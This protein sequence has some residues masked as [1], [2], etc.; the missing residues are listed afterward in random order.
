MS[1]KQIMAQAQQIYF[2]N[3]WR[4]K[5]PQY[6]TNDGSFVFDEDNNKAKYNPR[7]NKLPDL[8]TMWSSYKNGAESRGVRADY[9]TFKNYYDRIKGKQNR[10]FLMDLQ[11]AE[12]TGMSL[13][14]IHDALR[15]DPTLKQTLINATAD[16]S[17]ESN[18]FKSHYF[19]PKESTFSEMISDNLGVLSAAGV[20]TAAGV[21]YARTIPGGED[22]VKN[23][24]K[25]LKESSKKLKEAK[26]KFSKTRA[27]KDGPKYNELKTDVDDAK[28]SHSKLKKTKPVE[29][30][31][32]LTK[33]I[34]MGKGRV[35]TSG[36]AAA[37]LGPMVLES[38]LKKAGIADE[39]A[40]TAGSSASLMAGLGMLGMGILRKNPMAALQGVAQTYSGGT[41]LYNQMMSN[42]EEPSQ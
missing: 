4:E 10:D 3:Y 38:G 30:Y 12:I 5:I 15:D 26:E 22:A 17:D 29:R 27:K 36:Y 2:N 20:A 25:E 23:Y 33:N 39:S 28:S 19:P 41:N 37:A 32:S 9:L 6:D 8:E 11:N 16:G 42:P 34:K 21:D 31:K 1:I 13:D 14:K 7:S 18:Q 24:K 35:P 40:E